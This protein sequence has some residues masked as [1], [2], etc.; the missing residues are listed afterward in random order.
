MAASGLTPHNIEHAVPGT[1]DMDSRSEGRRSQTATEAQAVGGEKKVVIKSGDISH[2]S[3]LAHFSLLLQRVIA[4][5]NLHSYNNFSMRI[6]E[7]ITCAVGS[8]SRKQGVIGTAEAVLHQSISISFYR[9][10]LPII[11]LRGGPLVNPREGTRFKSRLGHHAMLLLHILLS[12]DRNLRHMRIVAT[13][14]HPA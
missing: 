3:M 8:Y 11:R 9:D 14:V 4:D 1:E 13:G 10:Q 2:I 5:I 7:W 12:A 6:G